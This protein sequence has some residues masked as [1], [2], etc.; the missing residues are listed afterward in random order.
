MPHNLEEDT[1]IIRGADNPIQVVIPIGQPG[2]GVPSGGTT[3]QVLV[4]KSNVDFDTD[5]VNGSSG[6]GGNSYFP[7]GW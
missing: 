6:S 2:V 5:W 3:G 4:K 1:V 7:G